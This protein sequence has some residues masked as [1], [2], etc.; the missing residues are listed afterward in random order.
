MFCIALLG[1]QTAHMHLLLGLE[2]VWNLFV[3][4]ANVVGT[5]SE[6]SLPVLLEHMRLALLVKH[7]GQITAFSFTKLCL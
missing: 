5:I 4:G 6:W 1:T 2:C 7:A 3:L